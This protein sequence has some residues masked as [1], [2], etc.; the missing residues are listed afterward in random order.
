ML[1]TI[2]EW[3]RFPATW[4]ARAVRVRGH[5][6]YVAAQA[7]KSALAAVLAWL[8]AAEWLT[9]PQA[10]LAPYVAVF[11]V[12]TTVFRSL[13]QAVVQIGTV[14]AGVLLAATAEWL[15]PGQT[16]AIGVVVLVGWFVGRWRRFGSNG[17]WVAITALLVIATGAAGSPVMLGERLLETAIGAACGLVVT[18]ALFPPVYPV[19]DELGVLAREARS[20]LCDMAAG[21]GDEAGPGPG[22]WVRRTGE[23]DRMMDRA[24]ESSQWAR[25]S[26]RLNPR[27]IA[28]RV[29]DQA[30][31]SDDVL[32]RLW[33]AVP[34]LRELAR[35]A[36]AASDGV[37][38]R[39]DD[40]ARCS[41]PA[42]LTALAELVDRIGDAAADPARFAEPV[43]F[44]EACGE[45]A[46]RLAELQRSAA[47]S[48]DPRVAAV[49]GSFWHPAHRFL[50]AVQDTRRV[51][52]SGQDHQF[53]G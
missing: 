4:T 1:S 33:Y 10:F 44:D 41:V 6:R 52:Q 45:C 12:E 5:E 16:A 50:T 2:T 28:A 39:A 13:R 35:V 20:L 15:V 8:V 30:S 42:L 43:R 47:G 51:P 31:A 53:G 34:A 14:V 9:L 7:L 25:E 27:P 37:L 48:A 36:E 22:G 23:I 46:D 38:D 26:V 11:L 18:A 19:G 17:I 32:D 24:A 29:R 40:A 21:L 3:V 49:L